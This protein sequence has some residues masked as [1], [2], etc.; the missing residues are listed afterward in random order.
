MDLPNISFR[1]AGGQ[2][3]L[4][5]E[6]APERLAVDSAALHALLAQ[7]GYG[8]CLPHE[9]AIASA[10]R[11]CSTE[12]N[13]FERLVAQRSDAAIQ[14]QIAPDEMAAEVSLCP[15]RGGKAATME[16]LMRALVEA[17][18][19]F[20]VDEAALLRACAPGNGEP[21]RVASGVSPEDGHDTVF[22]EMIPQAVDR[23]PQLDENGLIDY[24][25]HGTIAM[26]QS[27]APLMRRIPAT[28]G[29]VGH[30]IRGRVLAPHPGR[31]EPFAPGLTGAQVA[32]DD[33]NLLQAAVSGQP[34][35]V[36]CGI[37]VEPVLRVAEV[38]MTTGNIH[39]D[40]T[41]HVDGDVLQGMKV[42]A[43]GDIVVGGM[44]DG[45]QLE[46]GGNIK[47]TGGVIAHARLR[48]GGSVSA[49]FA[50]GAHI[51]AG[52]V[53][54]L[55]DMA[56]EC[57][58]QSL[59]QIIVGVTS[60]K[61]GRLI[62]GSASAMMLIKVPLLGSAKAGVT[63]LALGANPELEAKYQA[64]QERIAKEKSIEENLERLLKQLTAAGDPKGLLARV[65]ASRAHAVQVWG[66]S[67]IEQAELEKQ[68]A[69]GRA[70]KVEVSVGVD[71]AV[72]LCFDKLKARLRQ[73]FG[74]GSFC[75]DPDAQIVFINAA[76]DAVP[77]SL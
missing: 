74:V 47:V 10:A 73:E 66:Q 58:M 76:G 3:F 13:P 51:Y 60:P 61:R 35:R 55:D 43:S 44:V 29:V 56:L 71:G 48:A 77:T 69:L 28:A 32:R 42:Q 67:L 57:D 9:E 22:E 37:M 38:N 17:G 41:V 70:A 11:D 50:Q 21:V 23:A 54:A 15:A 72:D 59:N 19:M 24:R 16:D 64:L 2:V 52:T 14:V 26:V 30:S 65:K 40:G 31:D 34:V 53:I 8:D 33:P 12:Q 46:S 39:Y 63:Q 75:V 25:E 5:C 49:R 6:P 62:G 1:E 4:R 36:K 45:G 27:G 18:V 20:G 7:A 68:I